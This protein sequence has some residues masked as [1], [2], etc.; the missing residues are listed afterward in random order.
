[1]LSRQNSIELDVHHIAGERNVKA[2]FLFDGLATLTKFRASGVRTSSDV[3]EPLL[4]DLPK[5]FSSFAEP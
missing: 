2:D 1:M 4:W 5:G 3:N